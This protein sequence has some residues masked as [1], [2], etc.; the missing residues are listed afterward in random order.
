MDDLYQIPAEQRKLMLENM[1]NGPAFALFCDAWD[2][3]LGQVQAKINDP[4]TP[5]QETR[6]LKRVRIELV[7]NRHPRKVVEALIRATSSETKTRTSK[8]E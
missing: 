1:V 4:S 3:H 5:D 6:E 7:G 2:E 8:K